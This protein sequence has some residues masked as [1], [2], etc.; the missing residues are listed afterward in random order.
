MFIIFYFI[1]W[2]KKFLILFCQ[3]RK[4]KKSLLFCLTQLTRSALDKIRMMLVWISHFPFPKAKLKRF[5]LNFEKRKKL[6]TQIE[7]RE[8]EIWKWEKKNIF[9]EKE[10]TMLNYSLQW[11]YSIY[12]YIKSSYGLTRNPWIYGIDPWIAERF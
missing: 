6:S 11:S 3:K 7:R 8:R 12:N 1:F 2:K 5:N 10:D 9:D 4:T